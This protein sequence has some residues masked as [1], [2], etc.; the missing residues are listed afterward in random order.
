MNRY[1]W[2]TYPEIS[3]SVLLSYFMVLTFGGYHVHSKSFHFWDL[4]IANNSK[5][6]ENTTF[7]KLDLSPSSVEGKETS[8][9]LGPS[10]HLRTETDPVSETF[11]FLDI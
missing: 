7:R 3:H 5:Y 11:C 2:D 6:L 8:T 9:L 4:S 1:R 10:P